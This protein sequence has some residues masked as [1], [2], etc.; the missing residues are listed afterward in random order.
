MPCLVFMR[1]QIEINNSHVEMHSNALALSF[2]KRCIVHLY[3][4]HNV[5]T[6]FLHLHENPYLSA[7]HPFRSS[8]SLTWIAVEVP[9]FYTFNCFK[10]KIL[11]IL[12][13]SSW[14]IEIKHFP[15]WAVSQE[16][17]QNCFKHFVHDSLW[18]Q[19]FALE[20]SP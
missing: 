10:M 15:Q 17:S 1:L 4:D 6:E 8:S 19:I 3:P 11:P 5:N 12:G 18:K 14:K 7:F 20:H 2:K 9:L 13:K 16:I